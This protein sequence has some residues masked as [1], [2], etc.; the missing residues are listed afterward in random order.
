LALR[1]PERFLAADRIGGKADRQQK[2][3]R[4]STTYTPRRRLER[5]SHS[6]VRP[7]KVDMSDPS[8]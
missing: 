3:Q 6:Y 8:S 7:I 2:A 5:V 1:K 4:Q